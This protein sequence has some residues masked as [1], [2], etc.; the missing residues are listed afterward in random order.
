MEIHMTVK[1]FS[2]IYLSVQFS[3]YVCMNK[4]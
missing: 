2:V 4:G 1:L 3:T